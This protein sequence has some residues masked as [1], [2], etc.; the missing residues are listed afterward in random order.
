V[1]GRLS[2]RAS[3]LAAALAAFPRQGVTLADLWQLFDRV[4]P[5]SATS[6]ARRA[7]LA[8]LLVE[9]E[10]G[11]VIVMPSPRS[12][13]RTQN[14]PLPRRVILAGRMPSGRASN[15]AGSARSVA[16]RPELA[17]A[18]SATT[19]LSAGQVETLRQ[20]NTWLRD[21]QPTANVPLRERSY[22]IFGDEKQLD[23]LL[24]TGLFG[25][26]RLSLGLLRARRTCPPLPA[27]RL[28]SGPLLLVVENSDTFDT[29]AALL[30]YQPDRVGWIAWG[31]GQAFEASVLSVADLPQVT[32]VRY[33]GDLD[34]SGLRIP[35]AAS[36]LAASEG[37]PEVQPATDLYRI[38]LDRG[39]PQRINSEG[40]LDQDRAAAIASW[41]PPELR[42][43]VAALLAAGRRIPQEATGFELLA[44]SQSWRGSLR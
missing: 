41:L 3:R 5:V 25:P 10:A 9:L 7:E 29:L 43:E 28:G 44:R 32:E 8:A 24:G 38:L 27:R 17:W 37:L 39:A 31:A 40:R 42:S 35:A 12:M 23:R 30:A 4:D 11:G 14:P 6:T 22:E 15:A 33:Y 2:P 1:S 18:A 34:A 20:I 19:R 13:D 16:W 26:G 36:E 21:A